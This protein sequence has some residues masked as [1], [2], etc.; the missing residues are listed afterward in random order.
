MRIGIIS[1][2]VNHG[3]TGNF[4][5]TN[6]GA[7]HSGLGPLIAAFI[8]REHE[9]D[10]IDETY[11]RIDWQTDYG[12][13]FLGGF[14][15]DFD[16]VRQISHYWRKRGSKTVFGGAL[17]SNFPDLCQPYFDTI[18]VGDIEGAIP[19]LLKDFFN[20][21]LQPRYI[22]SAF[23][24]FELPTPRFDLIAG[25]R[26]LPLQLEVTR[27]CPFSCEFCILTA[28]GTRYHTRSIDKVIGSIRSAQAQIEGM[29]PNWKRR[30]IGF[31]DNNIGGNPNYLRE[32][33]RALAPLKIKWIAALTFNVLT[34]P[35]M[36]KT[37]SD[38]GCISVYVGLESLNAETLIDMRK[39]Q[40]RIEKTSEVIQQCLLHG[41]ILISGM[42]ISP[43]IDSIDYMYRL[44]DLLNK[45]NLYVPAFICFEAPFPGT[46]KFVRL[47]DSA[48][49]ALLPNALLRD[50]DAYTL[51][52]R[53][54]D[55]EIS[56]YLKAYI[57]LK[58]KV[59]GLQNRLRKLAHDLPLLLSSKAWIT[60]T[61]EIIDTLS[62]RWTD[63]PDRTFIA[64]TDLEPPEM[65]SIPFTDD[66]FQSEAE[67]EAI[68]GPWSV[69][70]ESGQVLSKWKKHQ[71]VFAKR[72]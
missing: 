19:S 9:I 66:D 63:H 62:P 18:V 46:P 1:V 67:R 11:E 7:P 55:A 71:K 49:P 52:V 47:A 17:A 40:N 25:R 53:P 5:N 30:I 34:I 37:L 60:S 51:V 68:T 64:G 45:A 48:E 65:R 20:G 69:T 42:M 12:L 16:R 6:F 58:G 70:D 29:I 54:R 33:C 21:N 38:A 32:L 28:L 57:E 10:I 61:G 39:F 44:P 15:S 35:G 4:P 27:G 26:K 8:P 2:Y 3:R 14:H 50:F 43:S 41:I 23:D 72:K 24:S 22:S 31:M 59:F 56:E 36:I 13:L